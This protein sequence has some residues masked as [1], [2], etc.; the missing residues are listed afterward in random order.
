[1]HVERVVFEDKTAIG[2]EVRIGAESQV[3]RAGAE[4]ILSCGSIGSPHLLELSGIGQSDRLASFGIKVTADRVRVG[5]NLQDHLQMRPVFR[6]KNAKTLNTTA[7]S[8]FGKAMIG[9]E[10]AVSQSGPLSM[11]PSQLGAFV[12]SNDTVASAD[13]QYHFQPLSLEKF[14]GDLDA[15]PAITASVCNLRPVSRGSVH[16]ASPNA[17]VAPAIDPNY[18]SAPEDRQKMVDALLLT[19]RLMQAPA[20]RA[21]DPQEVRPGAELKQQEELLAAA[22]QNASSIFHPVGTCAMG[23]E[24]NAVLDSRLRVRGVHRLRVIDASIMPMIT[25]GNTNA[26]TMAIAEKGAAMVL[27]DQAVLTV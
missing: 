27:E 1:V 6:V 18:L 13:L 22:M 14:G 20:M 16:L 25:S 3:I 5:E 23:P 8:L 26:P 2:V 17:M 19:R 7:N 15:F 9:M 11:A 4:V 10:Y 21:Y 24:D 12:R